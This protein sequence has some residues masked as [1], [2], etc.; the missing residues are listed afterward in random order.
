MMCFCDRTH[1]TL[2]PGSDV[3][4]NKKT[5]KSWRLFGWF[6]HQHSASVRLNSIGNRKVISIAKTYRQL[7]CLRPLSLAIQLPVRI[8]SFFA[9]LRGHFDRSEREGTRHATEPAPVFSDGPIRHL[10]RKENRLEIGGHIVAN[11]VP[12]YS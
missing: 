6:M 10:D 1:P 5:Q 12:L 4:L 11:G 7:F 2:P 3:L 9:F 8:Y